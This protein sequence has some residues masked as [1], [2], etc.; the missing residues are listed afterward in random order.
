MGLI[1]RGRRGTSRDGY[2]EMDDEKELERE[3]REGQEGGMCLAEAPGPH[4]WLDS[5]Y[6]PTQMCLLSATIHST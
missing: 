5:L 3:G 6:L 2:V 4:V 1:G